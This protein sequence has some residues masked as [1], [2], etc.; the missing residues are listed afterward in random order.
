MVLSRAMLEALQSSGLIAYSV[1][2]GFLAFLAV[3]A[4]VVG[5]IA[6]FFPSRRAARLAI[7]DAIAKS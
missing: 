2:F 4:G 1:P 5:V 7:L 6:A 3:M